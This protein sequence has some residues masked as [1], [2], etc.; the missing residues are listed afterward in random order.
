[1]SVTWNGGGS[2]NNWSNGANWL[3]GVAPG[4]GA[5]IIFSGTTQTS[6]NN[7]ISSGTT[8]ASIEFS[9]SNFRL[10]GNAVTLTSGV[11]VDSGISNST[12]SLPV[13]LSGSN[14]FNIAGSA[15]SDSG[16]L[17]GAGSLTK[18]GSGPLVLSGANTRTGNTTLSAGTIDINSPTALGTGTFIIGGGTI[19]NT[20]GQPVT[21][22]NTQQ[23]NSSYTFGGTNNLTFTGS[24]SVSGSPQV[25][26]TN[27]NGTLTENSTLT[28]TT[29][30]GAGLTMAGAGGLSLNGTL[31]AS[32]GFNATVSGGALNLGANTYLPNGTMVTVGNGASGATLVLNSNQT[33]GGLSGNAHGSVVLNNWAQLVVNAGTWSGTFAGVISGYGNV[34]LA[35]TTGSWTL[36]GTNTLIGG[37]TVNGGTL[38]AGNN[39]ALGNSGNSLEVNPAGTFNLGS[40]TIPV[41]ALGGYGTIS[42]A[43]NGALNLATGSG[44]AGANSYYGGTFSGPSGSYVNI[45]GSGTVTFSGNNSGYN[46]KVTVNA[47]TLDLEGL[48]KSPWSSS[49]LSVSN[50]G[51]VVGADSP[52]TF[53]NVQTSH[54]GPVY[55][56][57]ATAVDAL[58]GASGMSM[59]WQVTDTTGQLVASQTTVATNST[60]NFTP[61]ATAWYQVALVASD[62]DATSAVDVVSSGT[63][64]SGGGPQTPTVTLASSTKVAVSGQTVSLTAQLPSGATGTVA[65]YDGLIC[66]DPSG[67]SNFVL[68]ASDG[69]LGLFTASGGGYSSPAGPFAFDTLT[70]SWGSGFTLSARDGTKETF[71]SAGQ[72]TSFVDAA[73]NTTTYTYPQAGGQLQYVTYDGVTVTTYSYNGSSQLSSIVNNVVSGPGPVGT[74]NLSYYGNGQ[75]QLI[76]EKGTDSQATATTTLTYFRRRA[77][78]RRSPTCRRPPTWQ[79]PTPFM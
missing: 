48:L 61:P 72:Q 6:T 76:T 29:S 1:L 14:T 42:M 26:V 74:T 55:Q 9:A 43:A 62:S 18:T 77:T 36:S 16:V 78:P 37:A 58:T 52:L 40:Y 28:F 75:L 56:F 49:V 66:L 79:G 57:S 51:R 25:T 3:G 13:A 46:G 73:D 69:T 64:S 33:I 60:F 44:A 45:S 50:S 22:A 30:G 70:G 41:G 34:V 11:I 71:N 21:V 10:A 20:S 8:F 2:N 12:I 27:S 47:A 38:I 54:N 67:A 32:G 59:V 31:S 23:W 5:A 4:T 68:G 24:A 7:D 35:G 17:S 39:S 15:L 19:D 65:F 53:T 63:L